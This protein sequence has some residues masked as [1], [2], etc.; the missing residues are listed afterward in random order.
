MG[1]QINFKLV[2]VYKKTNNQNLIF[3]FLINKSV[4]GW[5]RLSLKPLISINKIS[6]DAK[7][8]KNDR[9]VKPLWVKSPPGW[10]TASNTSPE[11]PSAS[12]NL[13]VPNAQHSLIQ[14]LP[15]LTHTAYPILTAN[16]N[17][18]QLL[19]QTPACRPMRGRASQFQKIRYATAI[20]AS[21]QMQEKKY[22]AKMKLQD[23]DLRNGTTCL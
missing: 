5:K 16:E 20:K 12:Q 21:L 4:K 1:Q 10:V 15:S 8:A 18:A 7:A 6:Y 9:E 22:F 17:S 11:P 19:Q 14:E 2:E 13:A 23:D 3:E